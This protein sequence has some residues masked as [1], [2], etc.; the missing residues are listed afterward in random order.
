VGND[1]SA[2][3]VVYRSETGYDLVRGGREMA[4]RTAAVLTEILAWPANERGD[5]AARLLQSLDADLDIDA[6]AAWDAEILTRLDDV[7]SGRVVGIPWADARAQ[8]L[9][10]ID[11]AG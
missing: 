3:A 9:E 2:K 8:I 1:T 11:G 6:A 10:D 5:L 4:E 7:R